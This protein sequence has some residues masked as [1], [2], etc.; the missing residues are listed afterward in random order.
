MALLRIHPGFNL[1]KTEQ[2]INQLFNELAARSS[3]RH[4]DAVW[5]PTADILETKDGWQL[6]LDLPGVSPDGIKIK[7]QEGKL[8]I[9][10]ERQTVKGDETLTVHRA[11]RPSGAF[12][13][14]FNLPKNCQIEEIRAENRLGQLILHLPK[15]E[16]A[17]PKEISITVK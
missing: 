9:S 6:H 14:S 13:R 8:E 7:V 3:R 1:V 5:T 17:K 16:E 15:S 2:D 12:Y 4:Q 11:E 10:G